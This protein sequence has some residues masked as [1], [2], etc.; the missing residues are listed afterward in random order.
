M[1][2]LHTVH[3]HICENEYYHMHLNA[4]IDYLRLLIQFK[5][6]G[7]Y[8]RYEN[9]ICTPNLRGGIYIEIYYP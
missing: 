9:L 7:T 4:P 5:A 8:Y 2:E 1:V 3:I 6:S